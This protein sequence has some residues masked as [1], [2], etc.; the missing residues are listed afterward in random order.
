MLVQAGLALGLL[1]IHAKSLTDKILSSIDTPPPYMVN[2]PLVSVVIPTYQEEAYIEDT[3]ASIRNQTYEPI[4]IIVSDSS[5]E[6]SAL[7]TFEICAEYGARMTTSPKKNVS[8]GR[9]IGTLSSTGDILVIMDADCIMAHDFVERL[10]GKLEQGAVM[11]HGVDIFYDTNWALNSGTLAW[12]I[13]KPN[14][15]TTGRGVAIRR[16][17]YFDIGGYDENIDPML[18]NCREDLDL[19]RRVAEKWGKQSVVIDKGAWVATVYRR[20]FSFSLPWQHLPVWRNRGWREG[21]SIDML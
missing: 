21:Q 1:A 6:A 8:C 18:P 9:N 11:A 15:Y 19:G 17:D 16:E 20:P 13:F 3:L 7:E 5:P 4:E 10:V 14:N 2:G 12:A